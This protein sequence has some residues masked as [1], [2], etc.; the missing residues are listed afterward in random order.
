[1]GERKVLLWAA[2]ACTLLV[3]C[4]ETK[5]RLERIED[6]RTWWAENEQTVRDERSK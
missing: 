1:M 4:E 6:W 2:L 3:G 5:P